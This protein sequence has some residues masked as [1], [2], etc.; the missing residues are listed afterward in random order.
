MHLAYILAEFPSITEY[1]AL[2][3]INALQDSG[4]KVDVLAAK[5]DIR[6]S[7]GG[8]ISIHYR[9]HRASVRAFFSILRILFLRPLRFI[10]LLIYALR[11]LLIK[12]SEFL[13][14]IANLHTVCDFVLYLEASHIKHLHA[15]FLSWPSLI[16]VAVKMVSDVK[17]SMSAHSRDIYVEAGDITRKLHEAEFVTVC[18]K[19][20]IDTIKSQVPMALHEKLFLSYHGIRIYKS[21]PSEKKIEDFE[22]IAV[23]RLVPKKGFFVLIDALA[24][25]NKIYPK[26]SMKIIGSGYLHSKLS[27]YIKKLGLENNVLMMGWQNHES[28]I[29]AIGKASILVMPSIRADDGDVDGIPNVILEAFLVKTPVVASNI[30]S[31]CEAI[32]H[33]DNGLLFESGNSDDLVERIV[34]LYRSSKLREEICFN[35]ERALIC[36]FDIEKNITEKLLLFERYE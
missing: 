9:P 17:I 20:G 32:R 22:I 18:T 35:A 8:G 7:I 21:K 28:T 36:D 3:E 27:L 2:R 23:G 34:R 11:L 25:L 31:I 29:K 16:A 30:E 26:M 24:K 5:K 1:F 4:V 6:A 33:A 19:K 15:F 12:P 14:L 10:R 13:L